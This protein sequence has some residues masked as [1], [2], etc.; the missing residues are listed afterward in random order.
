MLKSV[1]EGWEEINTYARLVNK[2]KLSENVEDFRQVK[3]DAEAA[4]VILQDIE[5]CT[6]FLGG[7]SAP[8]LHLVEAIIKAVR[9]SLEEK[10]KEKDPTF[11]P[12]LRTCSRRDT[13]V[14]RKI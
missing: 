11:A 7:E 12:N 8:T 13:T 10:T 3:Q 9:I 6:N 1:L 14:G 2:E 5:D 4:L